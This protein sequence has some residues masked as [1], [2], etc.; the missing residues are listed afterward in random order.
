MAAAG[1]PALDNDAARRLIFV[2]PTSLCAA[3]AATGERKASRMADLVPAM[4]ERQ[5]R[6]ASRSDDCSARSKQEYARGSLAQSEV[7]HLG[8]RTAPAKPAAPVSLRQRRCSSSLRPGA[9]PDVVP[10]HRVQG[11]RRRGTSVVRP[12]RGVRL[13]SRMRLHRRDGGAAC[14]HRVPVRHGRDRDRRA[15]RR[16]DPARALRRLEHEQVVSSPRADHRR[17]TSASP[18]F[19]SAAA[20]ERRACRA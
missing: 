16:A 19:W 8:A 4:D 1:H 13:G 15:R 9:G 14:R 3:R 6:R 5:L 20:S 12:D 11:T 7:A 18:H 2:A 17:G 10:R